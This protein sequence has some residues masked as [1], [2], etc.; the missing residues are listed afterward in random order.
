LKTVADRFETLFPR[1]S[2][3]TIDER[4]GGWARAHQRF[5]ADG[6]I[7]DQVYRPGG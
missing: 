2:L 4:F 3:F 1:L 7:F 6:A 5:F